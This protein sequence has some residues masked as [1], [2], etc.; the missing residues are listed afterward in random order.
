MNFYPDCW[1]YCWFERIKIGSDGHASAPSPHC[2]RGHHTQPNIRRKF[3][4]NL[5]ERAWLWGWN[6]PA[7][8]TNQ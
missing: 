7:F 1:V 2:Q 3:S 8:D 4:L 5:V 6:L